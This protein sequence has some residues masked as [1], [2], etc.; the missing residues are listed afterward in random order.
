MKKGKESHDAVGLS[1]EHLVDQEH[2]MLKASLDDKA[3][4]HLKLRGRRG[5][6]SSSKHRELWEGEEGL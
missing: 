6:S 5:S 1:S 2:L 3:R 4:S